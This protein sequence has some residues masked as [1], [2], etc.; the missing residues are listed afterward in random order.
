MLAALRRTRLADLARVSLAT[1]IPTLIA[2]SAI[3]GAVAA[4]RASVAAS[5][6]DDA[7]G[8][9]VQQRLLQAES[10]GRYAAQATHN[11]R[12]AALVR[13]TPELPPGEARDVSA[14]L[15]Q[16]SFYAPDDAAPSTGPFA[17]A[18]EQVALR[19]WDDEGYLLLTPRTFDRRADLEHRHANRLVGL[20]AVFVLA[21]FLL[22][23][24]QL[25]DDRARPRRAIFALGVGTLIASIV[26]LVVAGL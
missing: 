21:L 1:W 6:A 5:S 17:L 13:L 10:D 9:A 24:A 18:K 15:S 19:N 23:I 16:F 20:A 22:S 3:M 26:L 25:V 14:W 7:A 8:V 4:W 11:S 2:V 12:I